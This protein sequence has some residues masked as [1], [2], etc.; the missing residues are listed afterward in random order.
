[1]T[2]SIRKSNSK[3]PAMSTYKLPSSVMQLQISELVK[4]N[5]KCVPGL[6]WHAYGGRLGKGETVTG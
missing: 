3:C 1:M 6:G 2:L 4:E 5:E